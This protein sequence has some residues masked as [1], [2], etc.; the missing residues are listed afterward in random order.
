MGRFAFMIHPLDVS[1]YTRK[2]EF[3]KY[4]PESWVEG[5][6]K[7]S[8]PIKV[9]NITGIKS[10]HA[11]AEGAFVACPLTSRQLMELP[12]EYA[13]KKIIQTGK[14]AEK[15]G[16]KIIGLG[17]FTSVVG[18][19]G[20]TIANNLN[21]A[22]T[23]GNSYTVAT[24]LEGTRMAAFKMG[25]DFNRANIAVIGATGAIGKAVSRILARDVKNLTMVARSEQ[26]LKDLAN[27]ILSETGL[28][29]NVSTDIKSTLRRSDIVIA[30]SSA[31]D[32]IIEPED[33]KPGAIVCDVARPRD[34]SRAVI[35]KRDDV[36]VIDGGVVDVPGNVDFHFDFGFPKGTSMACMAETMMLAMEERYENFTIG[37]DLS[38][39]Q[40]DEINAIARKHG[41]KVSGFRSFERA[42][43]DEKIASIRV[44]ADKKKAGWS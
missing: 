21:I 40:I 35:E 8:P 30:V 11:E 34:V 42:L 1:D 41:F 2:F 43:D 27:I 14:L 10:E 24:A 44:S 33:L 22:V 26:N 16:A 3:A 20:M 31:V 32:A 28:A 9:S 13:L 5:I 29:V 39:E 38:V 23:T 12:T 37:R 7:Y 19:A 25:I 15:Q 17:A 4:L 36:L 18:D 6:F